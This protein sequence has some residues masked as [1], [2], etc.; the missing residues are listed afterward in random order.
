VISS[1]I[2]VADAQRIKSVNL[3]QFADYVSLIAHP[4]PAP[5]ILRLFSDA[6]DSRP[7]GLS[8]WDGAFL[9]SLYTTYPD[10]VVQ[11]SQMQT[12]MLQYIAQ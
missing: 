2:L 4:G 7:Q 12:R 11:I 1:V 8:R 3:G 10:N 5:T 9:K 6:E